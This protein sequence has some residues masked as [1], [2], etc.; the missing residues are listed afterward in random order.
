MI[1]LTIVF[2]KFSPPYNSSFKILSV[3][4]K[5]TISSTE[6]YRS[7]GHAKCL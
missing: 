2:S 5:S 3:I 1:R 4:S 7:L 6:N